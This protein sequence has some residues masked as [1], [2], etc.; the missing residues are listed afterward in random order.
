MMLKQGPVA[1]Q[2]ISRSSG[3]PAERIRWVVAKLRKAGLVKNLPRR[4]LILQ[5]APGEITVQE[6][7]L[8]IEE[9][10]APTAPCGG[11]YDAC[12][13]RGSCILAPLCRITAE[14]AQQALK[15][16]T[17]AELLG[18]RPDMPNCVTA[19]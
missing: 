11:N 8:A 10:A 1:I 16:F 19:S 5:R 7:V 12:A 15:S 13:S 4:G 9:P 6:L 2:D 18:L 14:S 17:L 3:F